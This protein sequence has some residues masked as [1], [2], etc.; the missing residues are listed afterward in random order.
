VIEASAPERDI[1]MIGQSP[2]R[3]EDE[4]LITGRG[5]FIDDVVPPDPREHTRAS[6]GLAHLVLVRSTH[7]CARIVRIDAASA[8]EL[9]GVR[10]FLAEDLPEL[11]RALPAASAEPTNPYVR[12]DTP[13]PQRALA[14]G[15]V[16]YVGEP[17]A[18]IVAP[19]PYR[20]TDAGEA[21]RIEYEPRPAVVDAEAAMSAGAPAVHEGTSNIVGHVSTAIGDVERAFREAE[22]IVEDHPAHVRVS[23]MAMETRGVAAVYD[24]ATLTLTVWAAHQAPFALRT[25]VAASLR[26]PVESVRVI[27]QDTGGGFGPKIA[28]YP[29]DVIVPVLAYRLGR[30]VK[31]IQTRA[32]FMLSSHHAREQTH[33]ARLAATREGRILG[34]D[35][36][37]VKDVG[38]YHYFT[39]REPTNTINHLPS[40]YRVPAFRAEGFS[41]VTN[42]VPSSPYRG[43]GRPEAI[44]VVERLL[45]RLAVTL[46][47]DPAEIRARNLITAQEMP[48]RPGLVY[49]DGV[50]VSYDGGDYPRELARTLELLDYAGWRARQAELRVEGRAVGLGIAA[51]LETG[52]GVNPGEW[53]TVKVDE[54]GRIEV[55][56]GVSSSGQ[57]H[58]TVFAQVCAQCLGARFEDIRVRGGDT[59]LV[60]HGYGTG[61]SRVAITTGNAVAQAAAAVKAK[62]CR[63]AARLLECAADDVRIEDGQ[64][65]VVG[66]P[67]RTVSLGH[68]ARAA[69][70]DRSLAELGGPGLWATRFYT[71]PTVTWASGVHAAVVEVDV[72][73][74]RLAVLRYVVVH[75]CG[76]QIHP[77][78]VDGQ[79][80]GGLAQGLGVALGEHIIYG[81]DGQL[82]TGTLMDYPVPRADEMPPLLLE[83]LDVTTDHNALGVRGV[84]EAATGP[85]AAVIVNALADAFGGRLDVRVPVLTPWRVWSLLREAGITGHG[86]SLPVA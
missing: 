81:D 61:A 16:R 77:V 56:I 23:S 73:T 2:R 70:Q 26:L 63:T 43:A 40:Q 15:E 30:P 38:A 69:L 44:L 48:Y 64:A 41:V 74:G 31:W 54:G 83:H 68:L 20:A 80:V 36:R 34:L 50:P 76:R 85:P 84:G 29:E 60:P 11:A 65:F 58:E 66:T 10:V 19:D 52:G 22:V 25:A 37:I 3:K 24:A 62:A 67:A 55:L 49:R 4:R 9:R 12:L 42:K 82:L 5:R 28:V 59:T 39:V 32:E 46:G 13:R 57:G 78:I 8:R 53:A 71:L 33:H 47:R 75:D 21:V 6:E 79:T 45:D 14:Q 17:I 35:V 1:P 72:E 18:A 86:A 27:V 51:Y 7:A